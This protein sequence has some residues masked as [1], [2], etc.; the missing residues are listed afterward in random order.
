MPGGDPVRI[1]VQVAPG[2]AGRVVD[3]AGAPLRG[4]SILA[5]PTDP[6]VGRSAVGWTALDGTF[7]LTGLSEGL[8]HVEASRADD[9]LPGGKRTIAARNGIRAGEAAVELVARS[10]E[11]I[12]GTLRYADGQPAPRHW[13]LA[14]PAAPETARTSHRTPAGAARTDS[15]G[16][17]RI[18]GLPTGRFR[19]CATEGD[20]PLKRLSLTGGEVVA[21]GASGVA[22]VLPRHFVLVGRVRDRDGSIV[23][24]TQLRFR[25]EES[26]IEIEAATDSAGTFRAEGLVAGR[27][28]ATAGLGEFGPKFRQCK[29]GDVQADA[30]DVELRPVD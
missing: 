6:P 20:D 4:L 13:V 28:S 17:F 12:A 23:R 7:R 25:H 29:L 3:A 24:V 5:V 8:F 22:L 30:G 9:T 18:D 11:S 15:D 27:W 21:S 19:L 10:T 1:I 16:R 26:G 14:L 2:I